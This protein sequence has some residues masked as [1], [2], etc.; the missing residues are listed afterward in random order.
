VLK[1]A[2]TAAADQ[3]PLEL[4]PGQYLYSETSTEQDSGYLDLTKAG[5]IEVAYQMNEQLWQAADGSGREV[6]HNIGPVRFETPRSEQNW[7]AAGSPP[8]VLWLPPYTSDATETTTETTY[9]AAQPSSPNPVATSGNG[10]QPGTKPLDVSNYPTDPSALLQMIEEGKTGDISIANPGA[11]T[12][13]NPNAKGLYDFG[14]A[15]ALLGTPET[16]T[17]PALRSALY[18]VMAGV[19]GVTL[20]GTET[21]RS[22][23][24]GTGIASPAQG[25]LR[26]EVIVDPTTG[27]L[28]QLEQVVVNPNDE[29]TGIQTYF[30]ATAGQVLGWTEY[31]SSGVVDSTTDQPSAGST[32]PSS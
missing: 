5:Q 4:G 21:D 10:P 19:P 16:G 23:R 6:D 9:T 1:Q 20:L 11:P 14:A 29:T 13:F 15:A 24:T 2:A 22:G 18:Q 31:L 3:T 27:E 12:S 25:G 7:E 30:G 8:K 26:Y 17:S 32:T 28:L